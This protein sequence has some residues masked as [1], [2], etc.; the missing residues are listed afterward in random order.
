VVLAAGL[1]LAAGIPLAWTLTRPPADAGGLPPARTA[2]SP[3]PG[4]QAAESIP[5]LPDTDQAQGPATPKGPVT[6]PIATRSA[7]IGD[8]PQSAAVV[9]ERLRVPGIDLAA[10]IVAVGVEPTGDMEVPADVWDV[11]WYEH[12]PVPGEPGTA[13]LG[14]HVDS[15]EQGRGAFFD[16]R[17]LP[18]G[19]H[20]IVTDSGG[21]DRRFEV[22]ARRAYDKA[23]LPVEDVFSRTGAPRLVLI[24]CGGDFDGDARAYRENIVVYAVPSTDKPSF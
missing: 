6:P 11:G 4:G 12:G 3:S 8:V 18:V 20:I 10:P 17:R 14:A 9:P 7:R 21:H 19:A 1:A 22:V 15:R 16:L 13:V 24:T 5:A 23:Q 2:A